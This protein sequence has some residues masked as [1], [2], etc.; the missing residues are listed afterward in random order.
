MNSLKHWW[1]RRI[2]PY[3][4]VVEV[5]IAVVDSVVVT[6]VWG[7]FS[8][9]RKAEDALVEWHLQDNPALKYPVVRPHILDYRLFT[10]PPK[11]WRPH[12]RADNPS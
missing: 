10:A 2:S 3:V 6:S 8:S 1:H 12:D 7:V 4:Y 11:Y 9:Q 5:E